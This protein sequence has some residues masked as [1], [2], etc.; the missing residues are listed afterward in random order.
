MNHFDLITLSFFILQDRWKAAS[1]AVGE[2][3][4]EVLGEVWACARGGTDPR[5]SVGGSGNVGTGPS[6]TGRGGEGTS[7]TGPAAPGDGEDVRKD[8]CLS[9]Y[10][11]CLSV[12]VV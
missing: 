10:S 6:V 2:V 1:W 3:S 9:V 7:A 8:P 11:D 12:C 5:G 4:E